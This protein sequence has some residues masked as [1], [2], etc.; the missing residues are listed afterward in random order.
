[1]EGGAQVRPLPRRRDQ[2][3][4]GRRVGQGRRNVPEV[5]SRPNSKMRGNEARVRINAEKLYYTGYRLVRGTWDWK[6]S[7]L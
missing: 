6:K 1:M 3:Q 5:I 4:R 2:D 7:A